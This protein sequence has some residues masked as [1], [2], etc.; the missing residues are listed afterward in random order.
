MKPMP[1]EWFDVSK[2]DGSRF[3]IYEERGNA[4]AFLE[5]GGEGENYLSAAEGGANIRGAYCF[6]ELRGGWVTHS[7]IGYVS[8]ILRAEGIFRIGVDY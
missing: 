4:K 7:L 2:R 3:F 5:I 6:P 8:R 1:K